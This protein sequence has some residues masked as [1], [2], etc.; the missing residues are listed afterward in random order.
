VASVA[1]VFFGAAYKTVAALCLLLLVL[2][3]FPSGIFGARDRS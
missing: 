2:L 3:V 1:I